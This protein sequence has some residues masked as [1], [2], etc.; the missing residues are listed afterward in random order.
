MKLKSANSM[1]ANCENRP[2]CAAKVDRKEHRKDNSERDALH[3][4]I[5]SLKVG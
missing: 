4:G 1:H 3:D 2:F 5:P